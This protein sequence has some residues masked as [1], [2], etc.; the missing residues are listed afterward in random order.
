MNTTDRILRV[1]S[2]TKTYGKGGNKTEAL[3]GITFD[4]RE[5]EL[6]WEPAVPGK[7]RFSTASPP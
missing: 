6:L 7:Q 4:V 3:R 5:G 1:E 2:L